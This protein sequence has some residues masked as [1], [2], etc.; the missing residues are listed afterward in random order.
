[1]EE[2]RERANLARKYF[3]KVIRNYFEDPTL[4]LLQWLK[5]YE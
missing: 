5:K 4:Y 2:L 1:M 3:D